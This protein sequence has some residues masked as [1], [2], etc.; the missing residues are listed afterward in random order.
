MH[1]YDRGSIGNSSA[2]GGVE[3]AGVAEPALAI[4]AARA[5]LRS[6]C[7]R[8]CTVLLVALLAFAACGGGSSDGDSPADV[9]KDAC[10]RLGDFLVDADAVAAAPTQA[11]AKELVKQLRSIADDAQQAA[12]D[13]STYFALSTALDQLLNGLTT[14]NQS[15]I[16]AGYRNAPAQCL[17]LFPGLLPTTSAPTPESTG[18]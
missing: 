4:L 18:P 9:A 10:K 3:G 11:Q 15:Q 2:G 14:A 5:S 17:Q 16:E 6:S 8:S 7:L 13:D 1:P 12:G